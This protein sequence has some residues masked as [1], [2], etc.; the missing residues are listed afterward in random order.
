MKPFSIRLR[1]ERAPREA[2]GGRRTSKPGVPTIGTTAGAGHQ[3]VSRDS[4]RRQ[5]ERA[6]SRGLPQGARARSV[7][8]DRLINGTAPDQDSAVTLRRG[9]TE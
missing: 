1:P 4:M 2:R 7:M 3:R 9:A 8:Q 6:A 5:V